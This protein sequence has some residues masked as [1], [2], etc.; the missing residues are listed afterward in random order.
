MSANPEVSTG[1]PVSTE[2]LVAD[3]KVVI[4][5]AEELLR[6]TAGQTGEKLS[7]ARGR[8]QQSLLKAKAGLA[9]AQTKVVEKAKAVGTA[10]D[11]YV[12]EKPWQ[13]VGI[14][15]GIGLVVGMLISSRR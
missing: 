11:Q 9:E 7:E 5:D 4:H 6:A 14:A 3:F 8:I 15:A 13:A 1:K 10:T 12:H 2:Q